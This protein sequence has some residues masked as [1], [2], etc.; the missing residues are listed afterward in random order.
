M[1]DRVSRMS[2]I[3]STG[4]MDVPWS[5]GTTMVR[6][7]FLLMIRSSL[8]ALPMCM[9]LSSGLQFFRTK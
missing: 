4:P 6:W 2:M 7:V 3:P 5:T 1:R 8:M 9:S